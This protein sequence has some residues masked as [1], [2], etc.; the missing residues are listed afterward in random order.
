MVQLPKS[1]SSHKNL[2]KTNARNTLSAS[3]GLDYNEI[4]HLPRSAFGG[5][6]TL[7][8]IALVSIPESA[9]GGCRIEQSN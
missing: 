2:Y 8:F 1:W 9:F 7:G 3:G 5:Q 4:R 6:A